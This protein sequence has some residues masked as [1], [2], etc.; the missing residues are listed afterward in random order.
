L[1]YKGLNDAEH[2]LHVETVLTWLQSYK[3]RKK[4]ERP[5]TI[6]HRGCPTEETLKHN[7]ANIARASLQCTPT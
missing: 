2:L 1:H 6:F 3:Q 4:H 7:T 5:K